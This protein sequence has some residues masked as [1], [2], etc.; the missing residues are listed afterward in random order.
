MT[1]FPH[2]IVLA[3]ASPRRRDL[4]RQA[5]FR[6]RVAASLIDE[7]P[8]EGFH[9]PEA[10]VAHLAWLKAMDVA[11]REPGFILGADTA[12]CVETKFGAKVLG[13]PQDRDDAHRILDQLQGTTHSTLTGVCIVLPETPGKLA[14]VDVVATKVVMRRLSEN[15]LQ[16]YLDTDAWRDKAG[17]YG[18]QNE[19]DPFVER[20][21]G[22]FSNVVGLPIER[23]TE[24]FTW[25]AGRGASVTGTAGQLHAG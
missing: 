21:E 6:F 7:P 8:P 22:S 12:C 19:G 2:E 13:K 1:P 9:S 15:R 18:I 14:I 17:A 10:Y 5:G 23:I 4:L 16:A 3:S 25:I 11:R 24:L 20:I